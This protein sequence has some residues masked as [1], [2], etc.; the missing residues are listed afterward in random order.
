MILLLPVLL[1][2]A[3]TVLLGLFR[4]SSGFYLWLIALGCV[5]I[6]WLSLLLSSAGQAEPLDLSAWRPEPLFSAE[7]VLRLGRS[8]WDAVYA[9]MALLMSIVLTAPARDEGGR[10]TD[11]AIF[12]AYASIGLLAMMAGNL[13]T[14]SLLLIVLDIGTLVFVLRRTDT[15]AGGQQAVLRLGVESIGVLFL[16]TAGLVS[17]LG[18]GG[19]ELTEREVAA[20]SI[21]LA[22]GAI[23]RLGVIPLP[24]GLPGDAPFRR[25]TG[26]LMRLLPPAILIVQLGPL[27]SANGPAALR[28]GL[29]VIGATAVLASGVAWGFASDAL[30]GRAY[31]VACIAGLT[32][33]LGGAAPG[34]SAP[35]SALAVLLMLGGGLASV[36]ELHTPFHRIWPALLGVMFL[37]L[38]V[39]PSGALLQGVAAGDGSPLA[40]GLLGIGLGLLGA[41]FAAMSLKP[42]TRWKRTEGYS[43]LLFGVGLGL[44]SAAG[45]GY[46]L[47][48][49]VAFSATT[50]AGTFAALA[51]AAIVLLV[52]RRRGEGEV[53]RVERLVGWLNASPLA[54]GVWR[55]YQGLLGVAAS[56]GYA[57]EGEGAF[58]WVLALVALAAALLAGAAG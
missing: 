52:R 19:G 8:A 14:L 45:L 36:A 13:L 56:V 54:H 40:M 29:I 32:L 15:A 44:F 31:L 57:L 38:P 46:G 10:A 41:G 22:L 49:D 58:L 17:T 7:L 50:A 21:L 33:L 6:A 42:V 2:L 27:W 4:R 26:A 3:G 23:L 20:L 9:G 18:R 47:R 48:Q 16:L 35:M 37:G 39:T 43:R 25:S 34:A 1:L 53:R 51:T 55:L 12:L 24:M 11:W 30:D 5:F 28:G